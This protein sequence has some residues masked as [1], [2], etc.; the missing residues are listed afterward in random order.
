M[1][2][3]L[4]K[5]RINRTAEN[6]CFVRSWEERQAREWQAGVNADRALHETYTFTA[7]ELADLRSAFG[8]GG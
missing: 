8:Q 6:N 1:A 7:E 2:R 3:K 4:P 5:A